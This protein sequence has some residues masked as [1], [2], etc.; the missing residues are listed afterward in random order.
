MGVDW[1]DWMKPE[2]WDIEHNNL[3]HYKLNE[4]GG[5]S[6]PGDPDLVE[7]H[8][9]DM[10]YN[11][12]MPLFA[13]YAKAYA[14]A[15]VWKW[16]YYAPSTLH[17]TTKFYAEKGKTTEKFAHV[18]PLFKN[19]QV[20]PT[21]ELL[22]KELFQGN[23]APAVELTKC[24][25][26]YFL[27]HFVAIPA[28]F[29]A[30]GGAAMGNIVLANMVLAELITNL[31]SFLTIVTNHC[32]RD[33]YRFDT[34]VMPKSAEFYLRAVI[35]SANFR[36]AYTTPG[37]P[38]GKPAGWLG[39]INDFLHGYLNYQIEHH[40]FPE[41]S[42]K[43]YQKAMPLVKESCERYGIPYVQESVWIRLKRTIDIMVGK[44]DMLQ[45][46]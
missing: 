8:F 15:L 1:L 32:G 25:A 6:D 11:E 3:H 43:S 2:A 31:H 14:L 28:P 23:F 41:L 26:P 12:N 21:V 19:D 40:M 29:Y 22:V 39:E 18:K 42:M 24:L 7:R 36:T 37:R 5:G 35:G 20:A 45:W 44:E 46:E 16:F 30:F 27:W 33:L 34:Q 17:I 4:T 13:R 38:E 10:R 9:A